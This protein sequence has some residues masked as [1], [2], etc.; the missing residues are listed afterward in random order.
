MATAASR[1]DELTLHDRLKLYSSD[2]HFGR[3]IITPH[4]QFTIHS[5]DVTV[6]LCH[7]GTVARCF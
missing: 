7:C 1:E 3:T 2:M 6:F 4:V 5:E